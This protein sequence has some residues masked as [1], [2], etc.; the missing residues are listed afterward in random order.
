MEAE[1]IRDG[2]KY[3]QQGDKASTK[4][5]FR[6][7]D[8]DL[9]ASY[10]DKAA[11][12]FKIA[13]SYD[14]AVQAYY[15]SSEALSKADAIHLAGKA[16]ES[17][18]FLL[19]QNLNQ[20]QRAA[21]AYQRASDYFMTQGSID[22]AAEQLDKAGR[23]L[24]AI[25]V[26]ASFNVYSKACTLYE[27]ED[28]GRFAVEIFKR[29]ISLLIRNRKYDRAVEMLKRQSVILQKFTSRTHLYKANLSILILIFAIGD[30]VEAG[31]QFNTMCSE[32]AE[33]A[34]QL[35]KAYD[36]RDQSLLEK[37]VRLQHV[38]FLDNEVVKLARMLTVPGETLSS[39][40]KKGSATY[41][42]NA[43]A[44]SASTGADST[45]PYGSQHSATGNGNISSFDK[46]NIN[47]N[48]YDDE[49]EEDL[50]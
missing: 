19:A 40:A 32:E 48:G 38:T 34:E 30:D 25:D 2:V 13:H 15:K 26:N 50:R 8:W 5:F 29:A 11:T 6:K 33:I 7:P 35:L 1:Q 45:A 28:R 49:D 3:M 23:V 17:A 37:T 42:S 46:L 44:N 41:N 39:A 14:Q 12:S 18:A 27:Q 4:G 43:Q 36:E 31:K 20:P 24:E 10:Y 9:A 16:L 21:E 47:N 22:R